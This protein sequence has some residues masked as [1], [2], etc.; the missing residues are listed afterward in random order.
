MRIYSGYIRGLREHP[1]KCICPYKCVT[2][3]TEIVSFYASAGKTAQG[4]GLQLNEKE[5]KLAS[6]CRK[7]SEWEEECVRLEIKESKSV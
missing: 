1:N 2:C 7:V 5:Q 6:D 4:A 3:Q